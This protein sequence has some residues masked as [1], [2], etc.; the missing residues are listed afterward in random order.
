MKPFVLIILTFFAVN[1]ATQKQKTA[2]TYSFN[3]ITFGSGG[4]FTGAQKQ[5]LLKN[6]GEVYK[7]T[8]DTSALINTITAPEID[9]ISKLIQ[10]I[11][12]KNITRNET[13]NITYHIEVRASDYT[14]KVT[15]SDKSSADDLK[16]LYK[17]LVKTIKK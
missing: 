10:H 2:P 15:W 5:F 13:G 12:F 6:T 14:K 11:D 8:G 17:K 16:N 9:S 4:G 7:I 1:C 3:E